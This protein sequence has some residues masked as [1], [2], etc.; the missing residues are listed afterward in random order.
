MIDRKQLVEI[1][2]KNDT[3]DWWQ[4][5]LF[6]QNTK[7]LLPPELEILENPPSEEENY[8]CFIYALGLHKDSE[9]LKETTGFI[10]DSFFKYI[11]TIGELQKTNSPTNGDYAVYQD[12]ENYP[13]NLT[14]IGVLDK[15]KIISK[16]AWG[17]LI[18][19]N[20]WDVPAEYG[21]EVFYVQAVTREQA[22]ALFDKHKE[23]NLKSSQ[24]I[25]HGTTKHNLE[26]IK[27]FKRYTPGGEHVADSIPSRI[28]ATYEPAYAV[29]HSFPWSSD[30]GLDIVIKNDVVTVMVPKSKQEVLN[31][32]VCVY[33]LPND[34]FSF[35][36]EED[37]GLTYHSTEEV[38][39]T[40][41]KCFESVTKAIEHFGG[42]I[43]LI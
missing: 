4:P 8:N 13:D 21:N 9:L 18:K 37:M 36:A 17:P 41:C 12:L 10:Y 22:K 40:D 42:K 38:V 14:H 32:A 6:V 5:D 11:L 43:K 3:K 20:L 2:M 25:Y 39:P 23:Y 34:T 24:P 16:W 27:P 26:V 29:A 7:H 15:D 19:H 1:I 31:Q 30:D 35:T 33:S 28:Y